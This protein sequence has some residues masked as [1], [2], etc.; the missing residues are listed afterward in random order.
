METEQIL[1]LLVAER[2]RLNR[3]IDALGGPAKRRG[4]PPASH[5]TAPSTAGAAKPKRRRT[6][7]P[8]QRKA[9]AERMRAFWAARRKQQKAK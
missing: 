9:Q 1:A 2:D 6:F 7:T 4:R 5:K 8:A 3:A